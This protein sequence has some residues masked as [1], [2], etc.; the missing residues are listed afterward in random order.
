MAGAVSDAMLAA[1]VP[2][3][4]YDEIAAVLRQWYGGLDDRLT[5]SAT[6]DLFDVECAN[7]LWKRVRRE[8]WPLE[9]AEKALSRVLNLP[10]RRVAAAE[11]VNDALR[12]AVALGLSVYDACYLALALASGL[13]LVTADWRLAQG[14]R[15]AGCDVLCFTDEPAVP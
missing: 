15:T 10:V 6:L 5:E 8:Q 4:P 3:A 7:A 11:F 14:A 12:L 2:Q 1:L 13:P 9:A